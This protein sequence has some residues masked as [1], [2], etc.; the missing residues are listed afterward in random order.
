MARRTPDTPRGKIA[1]HGKQILPASHPDR[2]AMKSMG[3]AIGA[4]AVVLLIAAVLFLWLSP[5]F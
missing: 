5:W 4:T 2:D 1:F 3:V